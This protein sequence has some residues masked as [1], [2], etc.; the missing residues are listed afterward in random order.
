MDAM[1]L[2]AVAQT[3]V[4]T[5]K[6]LAYLRTESSSTHHQAIDDMI[7]RLTN[8]LRSLGDAR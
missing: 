7:S 2:M 4:D 8:M 6:L 5:I 1:L 3:I